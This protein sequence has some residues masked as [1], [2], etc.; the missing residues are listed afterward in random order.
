MNDMPHS[1][2]I[3]RRN[4]M[5]MFAAGLLPRPIFIRQSETPQFAGLD[6]IEFYVA[7]VEKSRDFFVKLFGNTLKKRNDK[8][9][10]KLGP[11]Y[12]A[13]EPPRGSGGRIG[14]DHYSV[15][16]KG[17]EMP[18]LHAFLEQR[19]IMYQDYPSG[20]DTGITD[21]EGIRTQL[22]PEDGW[23][24]LSA[25]NF[26]AETVA[27]EDE[28]IFRP[29]GL[30]HVL[31]NVSDPEKSLSFY[32]RFLG[33]PSERNSSGIWFAAGRSRVGL[34]QTPQGQRAGVNHFC[35]SATPFQ[36]D[37]VAKKLQ[38]IGAAGVKKSA[39]APETVEFR[40]PDGLTIQ[41]AGRR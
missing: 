10:V 38:Q 18:K 12:M 29:T 14:V 36:L 37:D 7:N 26:P 17:L 2:L 27:M 41:V 1:A 15:S 30:D 31:L 22:S 9:Y 40:D 11:S 20:R 16:V 35:V 8:R 19:G 34:L 23:S 21:S 3:G 39:E 25:A 28:P 24:F 5:Q 33:T 4:L 6:R 32:Q 13:F